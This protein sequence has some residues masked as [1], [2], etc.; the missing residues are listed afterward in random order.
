I[1]QMLEGREVIAL[2]GH[3]H[4]IENMKKGDSYGPWKET[5]GIEKLPFSHL[6]VGAISGDWYSGDLDRN[7]LP[8]AY[9]RDGGRPGVVTLDITG[10]QY[11]ERF[12]VTGESEDVQMNVGLNSPHWRGWFT[13]LDDWRRENRNDSSGKTPPLSY[14]DLGD[15]NMVTRADLQNTTYVSTNFWM[16][17]TSSKVEVSINGGEKK[18][19]TRTQ[20]AQGEEQLIGAEYADPVAATRQLSVA[21]TS[22]ASTDGPRDTQGYRLYRGSQYGPGPARP[23]N[24][25]ADRM[26]HMWRY[27][28]PADLPKGTHRIEVT[29]TDHYGRQFTQSQA[30]T[31]VDERPESIEFRRSLFGLDN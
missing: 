28:L 20:A 21:R 15:P 23:G 16:G 19:A 3:S 5:F 29:A 22:Q 10:N 12:S 2:S 31:V 27:E 30:I 24:N 18:A 4:S 7:G 6:V 14:N 11:K 8:M 26:H 9:Q 17:T 1:H 25:L 13:T